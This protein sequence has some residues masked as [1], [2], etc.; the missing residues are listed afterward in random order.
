MSTLGKRYAEALLSLAIKEDKV[1]KIKEDIDLAKELFSS[2]K[3][4]M[5]IDIDNK[6]YDLKENVISETKGLYSFLKNVKLDK[7]TKNQL[8]KSC[9]ENKIDNLSL[10][11]IYILIEK[12]RISNYEEIFNEFHKLANHE[13]NIKEGIIE[14]VRPLD[15]VKIKELE[16]LLSNDKEKVILI[17]KLNENLISGFKITFEHEVIDVSM[18]EKI[19]KMTDML[20][21]KENI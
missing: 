2:L 13:L 4:K 21:G 10:Q 12:N 9:L 18:Q 14:S 11:F 8:V 17:P 15:E 19:R 3:I 1:K 7:E 16:E 6:D 20:N 5:D